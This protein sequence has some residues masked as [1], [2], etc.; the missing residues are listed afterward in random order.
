MTR[1][2]SYHFLAELVFD[3]C[4]FVQILQSQQPGAIVKSPQV[5][6]ATPM[7]TLRGQP[8]SRIVVGQPQVQV[9]Q[10]NTGV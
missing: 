5:T 7:V 6:L 4:V 9:K 2:A 3:V 8:H 1:Y 10:L